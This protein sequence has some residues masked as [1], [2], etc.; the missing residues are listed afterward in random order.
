MKARKKKTT[1]RNSELSIE[2]F[3][4][5]ASLRFTPD[6]FITEKEESNQKQD[7]ENTIE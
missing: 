2:E 3:L 5:R 4:Q 7:T 1:G 6:D